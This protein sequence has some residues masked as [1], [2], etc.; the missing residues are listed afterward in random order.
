MRSTYR[1]TKELRPPFPELDEDR[2][3]SPIA[4]L[5]LD[6]VISVALGLFAKAVGFSWTSAFFF[7]WAGGAVVT[8]AILSA[9]VL[10]RERVEARRQARRQDVFAAWDQDREA[11]LSAARG[12]RR[13]NA[14]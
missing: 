6:G 2:K 1:G 12:R 7:G 11:D 8:V 10:L 5:V 14:A 3:N 9:G 4:V 13:N